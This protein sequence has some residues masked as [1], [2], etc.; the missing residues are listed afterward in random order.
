MKGVHYRGE[1]YITEGNKVR[2]PLPPAIALVARCESSACPTSFRNCCLNADSDC[3]FID[4]G[5]VLGG[6]SMAV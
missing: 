3:I 2:A 6:R 5:G 4:F 1:L